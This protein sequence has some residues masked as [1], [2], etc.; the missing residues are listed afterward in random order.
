MSDKHEERI[1][2]LEDIIRAARC[3]LTEADSD[4]AQNMA[5][6]Y[7]DLALPYDPDWI[8]D[9]MVRWL[10]TAVSEETNHGR[11]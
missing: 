1:I 2:F 11:D 9:R 6:S 4:Q 5:A 8:I 10:G 3:C 7:L